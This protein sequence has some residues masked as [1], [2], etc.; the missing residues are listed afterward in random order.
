MLSRIISFHTFLRET[1]STLTKN[2]LENSSNGVEICVS[3]LNTGF[4]N[5]LKL[6]FLHLDDCL[7]QGR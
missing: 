5:H 7:N 2:K 4:Q 1:T 6:V 3:S